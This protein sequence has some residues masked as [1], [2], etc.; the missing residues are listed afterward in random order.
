[1]CESTCLR[2][3]VAIMFL[4]KCDRDYLHG[5]VIGEQSLKAKDP[6]FLGA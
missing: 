6:G 2:D 3:Y 1:M 5:T 4:D